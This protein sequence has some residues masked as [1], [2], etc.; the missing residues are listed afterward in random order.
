[1]ARR[2]R[3]AERLAGFKEKIA[4]QVEQVLTLAGSTRT[5]S[6]TCRSTSPRATCS[7]TGEWSYNRVSWLNDPRYYFA[8][9][10]KIYHLIKGLDPD[11][12]IAGPNTSVLYDQVKGFLQ[13]AKAQRR[14]CRT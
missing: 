7:A 9:W 4:P 13:Y 6:S 2:R 1:M 10:K 8:A 11:A 12:R 14:A 5:T 3:P